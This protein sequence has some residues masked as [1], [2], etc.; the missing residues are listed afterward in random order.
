MRTV[1]DTPWSD[2][3]WNR[4]LVY[5]LGL[6][7]RAASAFLRRRGVEVVGVDARPAEQLELGPLAGDA[8]VEVLAGGEPSALPAGVDGVVLSPGVPGDRPLLA[9]ARGRGVPVVA[10]VELAFPFLAGPVVGIT[11]SNGKS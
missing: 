2:A 10:E 6:S 8:G 11:G 4:V 3:P 7:G 1:V 9:D 5:G